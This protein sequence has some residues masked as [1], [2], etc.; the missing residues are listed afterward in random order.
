MEA[1]KAKIL[2]SVYVAMF[3]CL[4]RGDKWLN[5]KDLIT[6][7]IMRRHLVGEHSLHQLCPEYWECSNQTDKARKSGNNGSRQTYK[8]GCTSQ[9]ESSNF[10]YIQ[11]THEMLNFPSKQATPESWWVWGQFS[12]YIRANK[13][14]GLASSYLS[15]YCE[16]W[17]WPLW[18][19]VR[20]EQIKTA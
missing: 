18:H 3:P 10:R 11:T 7:F 1:L 20:R 14:P 13:F 2:G 5:G 8:M 6:Q 9:W 12:W 16:V 4:L 19:E 17:Q 15:R